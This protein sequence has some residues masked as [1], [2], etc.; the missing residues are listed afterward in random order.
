MTPSSLLLSFHLEET[1]CHTD[2]G[3]REDFGGM[4]GFFSQ[5][6]RK[7][8]REPRLETTFRTRRPV[9][10]APGGARRPPGLEPVESGKRQELVRP[11]RCRLLLP[12]PP[13]PFFPPMGNPRREP[14]L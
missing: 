2:F 6:A 5:T 8:E 14:P 1:G 4:A 12:P 13:L 3:K 11:R 9:T 7:E 10:R